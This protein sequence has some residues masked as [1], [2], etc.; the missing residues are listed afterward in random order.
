MRFLDLTLAT[1]AANLALDEALL[2]EAEAGRGGEVLR[3]WEWREP[4]VVLGAACRLAEEV[5]ED[6]CR[7][8]GV[9]ILRRASGGGTVL[10]GA[11]CLCF[12]LVLAY[13]R[14]PALREIPSS[15]GYILDRIRSALVG[16]LPDIELAGISDLAAGGRKFSGNAQQR[17]RG[18]LLH[19]GTLLYGFDL[20]LVGRYLRMPERQP[21]YRA[22]RGHAA[23]LTNLPADA[24]ELK[25]R[26]VTVWG[27]NVVSKDWPEAAI[28]DLVAKKYVQAAW[29]R[30]R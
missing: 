17:K 9:P 11:G 6:A 20:A 4:A 26:L 8:D 28:Q 18:H 7:A 21:A 13:D 23:F 16:L 25:H 27:A 15:Y 24:A 14:D 19:H 3:V 1:V 10:L 5:D 2:L 29:I 30:R 22:G 12:S